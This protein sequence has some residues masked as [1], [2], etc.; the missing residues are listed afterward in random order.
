[1]PAG[2]ANHCVMLASGYVEVL[3]S[4]GDTPIARE[5]REALA[6]YTGVHLA[7]FCV[8]D[9]A[10]HHERLVSEGFPQRACVNLTRETTTADGK[11]TTLRFTVARPQLNCLPEGRVQFLTH[12]TPEALW[13]SRWLAHPNSARALTDVLFCVQDT[14]EAGKR[15]ERYLGRRAEVV[16]GG[17]VLQLDRGRLALLDA[18]RVT[19]TLPGTRIPP[20]PCMVAYALEC[21]D[22]GRARTVLRAGAIDFIDENGEALIVA[23]SPVLGGTIVFSAPGAPPPWL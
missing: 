7:A 11:A 21:A 10:R 3:T 22:L 14:G 20:V 18:E 16:E 2:S 8:E 13:Q 4:I 12:H 19:A 23:P 1:M 17:R 5:V 15:Y 6:R 9:A